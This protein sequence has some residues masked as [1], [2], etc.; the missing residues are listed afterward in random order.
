[1]VTT[2]DQ[3][4]GVCLLKHIDPHSVDRLVSSQLSMSDGWGAQF[5]STIRY[6]AV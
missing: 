6:S 4:L 5:H 3:E 2:I 1:M